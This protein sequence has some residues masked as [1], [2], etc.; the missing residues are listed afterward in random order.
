[1]ILGTKWRVDLNVAVEA[2]DRSQD[3][4]AWLKLA[5]HDALAVA[6]QLAPR[7][8]RESLPPAFFYPH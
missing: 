1:M 7:G 5:L 4:P 2:L 6:P 8:E 3:A